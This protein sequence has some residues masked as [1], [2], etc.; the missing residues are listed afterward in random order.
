M[1]ATIEDLL[2][3]GPCYSEDL[4]WELAGDAESF[5]ALDVLC[6]ED[7][8]AEH[9]LW[10]V[11]RPELIDERTLHIF[12][13]ECAEHAQLPDADPRSLEAL[14]VKRLWVDGLVGDEELA[15]AVAGA[16]D[17]WAAWAKRGGAWAADRAAWAAW[18]AA[19][20]RT[21]W[22]TPDRTARVAARFADRAAQAAG[23]S[24]KEWQVQHLIALL[25]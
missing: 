21:A 9:R 2:G 18:A 5:S 14:R 19:S 23:A 12:A 10:V 13:C 11:L 6:R 4:I 3:W 22:A 7:I 15:S 17:A 1:R 16:W 20:N 24:Q 8:P 25:T